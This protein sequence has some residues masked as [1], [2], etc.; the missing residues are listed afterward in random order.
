MTL[1]G[2][3]LRRFWSRRLVWGVLATALLLM[4][5]G[6]TIAAINH[7]KGSPSIED[8]RVVADERY[9]I[10]A[11]D[12]SNMYRSDP[13]FSGP[14]S[15]E[16]QLVEDNCGWIRTQLELH[17]SQFCLTSINTLPGDAPC[18]GTIF[19]AP[20]DTTLPELETDMTSERTTMNLPDGSSVTEPRSGYEGVVPAVSGFLLVLAVV[21]GGSFVG[22]EYRAG[23]METTLLWEP[24]RGRVHGAKAVA[25]FASV[26]VVHVVLMAAL[27]AMMVV[28]ALIAGTTGGADWP[29]WQGLVE[30]VLR[31]AL[32]SALI[33]VAAVA[34]AFWVR[35]SAGAIAG[36]IGYLFVSSIFVETV[37]GPVKQW[38]PFRNIV[39]WTVQGDVARTV[40]RRGPQGSMRMDAYHHGPLLGL[41]VAAAAVGLVS[42]IGRQRFLRRDV[43]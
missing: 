25:V 29:F 14:G 9:Q 41:L 31:G 21:L 16:A 12:M 4:L 28:V 10:C 34:V 15:S 40:L 27:V 20:G 7:S 22:A 5:A 36:I 1:I 8:A 23:T 13:D 38:E 6:S 18:G 35:N 32:A 30:T 2:V 39:A 37:L 33:G 26:V 3:E 24:R 42:L 17:D 11:A 19:L 43:L